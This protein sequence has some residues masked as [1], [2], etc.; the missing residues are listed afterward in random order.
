MKDYANPILLLTIIILMACRSVAETEEIVNALEVWIFI[1]CVSGML[2]N[3][4]LAL[5]KAMARR[6]PLMAAVWAVS[7]MLLGSCAWVMREAPVG[8]EVQAYRELYE[9]HRQNPLERDAEGETLFTRAAA[10]G[11]ED[12][13]RDT[14]NHAS[15]TAEQINEAGVRAAEGNKVNILKL[16]AGMGMKADAAHDGVPLLHAAAQNGSSDAMEWLLDRGA[17]VDAR[18]AEGATPL[19]HATLS[20]SAKAVQTLLE[21][22]AD[23][24]LRDAT[25]KS[26][27]DLA[28]SV[29]ILQLFSPQEQ[30]DETD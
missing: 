1:L 6:R 15:P 16:L 9:T 5:A 24:Q 29:E 4:A 19:I 28:P 8:E 26:P 27:A 10:L 3:G 14:L 2:V 21:Y 20:G 22:G 13:V 23:T 30:T 17:N 11:K 7:Y 25:G 12:V 18:D